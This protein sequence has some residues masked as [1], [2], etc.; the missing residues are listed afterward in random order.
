MTDYILLR[1]QHPQASDVPAFCQ[2]GFFF[3][4]HEHLC[5][6]QSGSFYLLS[7][8][9]QRTNQADARCAFFVTANGI[10]SPV[11]APFGSIE[12]A[13]TLPGTVL[14]AF[15]KSLQETA[16]SFGA[17]TLRL[18]N[19]PHCYAPEQANRLAVAL[20]EQGFRLIKLHENFFLPITERPFSA[21]INASERRRLRKCREAGFQVNLWPTTRVDDAINFIVEARRTKEYQ[22]T[23]SPEQLTT[24]LQKFPD[25]FIVFTVNDADKIAAMT[26]A[27]RV[28]KDILYSFLPASNPD[29]Q[30]FSPLVMLTDG[31]VTY[32][33][34]QGI[35]LLDLGVSLDNDRRPKPGLIRFKQNLGAQSSPK[36]TVE[37]TL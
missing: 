9:N 15:I 22:L 36:M 25:Q 18:V 3:N 5:Q 14:D 27:V 30:S 21:T 1:Q 20:E 16:R 12:F 17:S 37:K 34:Q 7:A 6:Q 35:R 31:L 24:L 32:C 10:V 26:V 29:Y 8:L 33:R 11:A 19:Y 2:P 28:R 4:E 13:E 23:I